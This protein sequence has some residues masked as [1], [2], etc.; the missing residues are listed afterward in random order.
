MNQLETI[1]A[2]A[3]GY[4]E[5]AIGIIRLSGPESLNLVWSVTNHKSYKP[6]VSTYTK[7]FS[8]NDHQVI[9]EVLVTYFPEP[10]SYT[11]EDIVEIACHGSLP[12]LKKMLDTLLISGARLALP[13]EF[14]K[15][16]FLNGKMD[17]T[18]AEAVQDLI[19]AKTSLGANIA[20]DGLSGKTANWI[21]ELRK[22]LID[23]LSNLEAALDFPD[24]IDFISVDDFKNKVIAVKNRIDIA[25]NNFKQ[26]KILKEGLKVAIAGCPNVG[27]SSLLNCMLKE[28]RALISHIAGTTRDT[29]EE[30]MSIRDIPIHL[31]DTAG[32]H[33]TKDEIELMGIRRTYNKLLAADLTLYI[34]DIT[35]GVTKKDIENI[36]NL[37]KST[38]FI[39]LNKSDLLS[40]SQIEES[41]HLAQGVLEVSNVPLALS[42][43]SQIGILDLEA[44]IEEFVF[45]GLQ[46][47]ED[48]IISN[49]RQQQKLITAR[50]SLE[51][52]LKSILKETPLDCLA[53]DLKQAVIELGEITGE[54]VSEEVIVNIF[55]Q[56][57]VGK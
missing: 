20:L 11:G 7:I 45:R 12:V 40:N 36:S 21:S 23:V 50:E 38:V 13:G 16:A 52:V 55:E 14:T 28:E 51:E 17:L 25:I 15:R 9:D 27:K 33:K 34:L 49:I 32:L 4:C 30:Y 47:K 37:S 18:Q 6:R 46:N 10:N 5:S 29:I 39:I 24:E 26:G 57:C 1:I 42:A 48:L 53:V 3:T 54:H 8:A 35:Q 22:E 43:K 44:R 56:F 19:S 31:I 2:L 41:I